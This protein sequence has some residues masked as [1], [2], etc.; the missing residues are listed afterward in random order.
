M[1]AELIDVDGRTDMTKL[2][3]TFRNAAKAPK[4]ISTVNFFSCR[5]VNI[6]WGCEDLGFSRR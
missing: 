5:K 3:V 6:E 1:G 2:T 4:N